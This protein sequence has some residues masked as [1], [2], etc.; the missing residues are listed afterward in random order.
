MK[1]KVWQTACSQKPL[2]LKGVVCMAAKSI[3]EL[4]RDEL[5]RI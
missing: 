1:P 3:G 2:R 5:L 4:T